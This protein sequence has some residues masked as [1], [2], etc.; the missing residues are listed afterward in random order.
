MMAAEPLRIAHF[1][2]VFIIDTQVVL[3]TRPIF[4][5]PWSDLSTDSILLLVTRQVATEIDAKKRDGRLGSRARA[6]NKLLDV[7]LETRMPALVLDGTPKVQ[8]AMIANDPIDWGELDDLDRDDPDDRIVAQALRARVDEPSRLELLSHD[9]RPREAAITHGMKA[10]KLPE[11]WLLPPEP[12]PH[13]RRIA[14]M[15]EELDVL[16]ADQPQLSASIES[17]HSPLRRLVI[18]PPSEE[19]L[20]ELVMAIRRRHPAPTR[21][22]SGFLADPFADTSL[23]RRYTEWV[24]RLVD[25]DLP[26]L[27]LGAARLYAQHPIKVTVRNVGVI[28][29]AQ[30]SVEVRSGN[31]ILH[32]RPYMVRIFGPPPPVPEHRYDSLRHLAGLA[33]IVRSEPF[34]F[35]P[36]DEGP[37]PVVSWTCPDFR[38]SR[39]AS[40]A[41]YLQVE[42]LTR[43]KAQV[44]VRLTCSNMK[45][46]VLEQLILPVETV[47]MELNDVVDLAERKVKLP[48]PAAG[49]IAAA[50]GDDDL[51]FMRN[52]GTFME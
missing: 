39:T 18:G 32:S 27:H 36:E 16:R 31:A 21:P 28:S 52:D 23:P 42:E 1:D 8:V 49:P 10:T 48:P 9:L 44:E 41:V 35:Y 40:F 29:A 3:E 13:E 6:F 20:K 25:K 34:A 37:G 5:L 14:E 2:R 4:Q 26:A 50:M 12:S 7:Y 30:L 46:A 43:D 45:G 22:G 38:Q 15:R 11:T 17:D 19:Q 51:V 24:R 33:P 47:E